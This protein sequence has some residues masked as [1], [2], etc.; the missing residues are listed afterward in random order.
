MPKIVMYL[1]LPALIAAMPA[2]PVAADAASQSAKKTANRSCF[3]ARNLDSWTAVDR[4]TVNL[5]VGLHDYYQ[6][7]LLGDCP[8]IDWTQTIGMQSKGADWICSG[9]DVTLIVPQAGIGPRR[10]PATDLR[11]LSREEVAALPPKQKP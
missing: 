8:D 2:A 1:L 10:C 5:R 9:L 4:Q 11:K 3:Y 7:K 6:L